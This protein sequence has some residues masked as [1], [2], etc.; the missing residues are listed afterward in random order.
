M[1]DSTAPFWRQALATVGVLA[2]IL[3][4]VAWKMR[5]DRKEFGLLRV[6]GVAFAALLGS[7]PF[8]AAFWF[9]AHDADRHSPW[10]LA[11]VFVPIFLLEAWGISI[12]FRR[13]RRRDHERTKA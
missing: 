2:L 8:V 1:S 5:R 7:L 10:L 4:I 6:F 11:A 9:A 13:R 3:G 12:A